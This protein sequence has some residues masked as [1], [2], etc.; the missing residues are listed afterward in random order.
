MLID[1]DDC[2]LADTDACSDCVVTFLLDRP[3]QPV[4]LDLAEQRAL[5]TLEGAGLVAAN[6]FEAR[7]RSQAAS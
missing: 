7:S 3:E 1:C 5:R 6:R 2:V 4:V